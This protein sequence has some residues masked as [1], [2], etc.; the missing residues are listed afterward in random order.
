[1]RSVEGHLRGPEAVAW[2]ERLQPEHD[3]LRAALQ[4]TFDTGHYEDA[5]W[6]MVAASWFWRLRGHWYEQIGWYQHLLPHRH[7]IAPDLRLALLI[8]FYSMARALEDFETINDYTDELLELAERCPHKLHRASAW[9]FAAITATDFV[10]A[11]RGV[12]EGTD[13][14]A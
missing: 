3:N 2:F 11:E 8:G 1:M 4:W 14:G 12:G 6:L 10:Q 9:H 13:V 7:L 5:A